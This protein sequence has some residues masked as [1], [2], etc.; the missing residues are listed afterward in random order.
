MVKEQRSRTLRRVKVKTPGGSVTT[1]YRK[2]KPSKAKCHNCGELLKG[3]PRERPYKMQTMAKTSKRPERPYGGQLCSKCSRRMM[4]LK[5]RS[6]SEAK[7]NDG[8][9]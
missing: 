7:E 5:S 2:R 8:S 4:I 1:Q 9:R 6:L 3:V